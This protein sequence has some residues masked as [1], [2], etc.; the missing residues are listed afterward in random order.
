MTLGAV[1]PLAEPTC[2]ELLT[3]RQA[4]GAARDYLRGR[5]DLQ[6]IDQPTCRLIPARYRPELDAPNDAWSVSF[7]YAD[8]ASRLPHHPP[9]VLLVDVATGRVT[10]PSML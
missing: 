9:L 6:V 7:P 2:A 5:P 1:R 10:V 3:K 4:I 8:Q